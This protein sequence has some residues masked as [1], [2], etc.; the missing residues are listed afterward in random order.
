MSEL[1]SELVGC[2][3]CVRTEEDEYLTGSPEIPCRVMATDDEWIRVSFTDGQGKRIS[4]ISRIDA[5]ADVL[6]FEE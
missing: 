1:L 5:L 4:R 6:I 2:R 3:C